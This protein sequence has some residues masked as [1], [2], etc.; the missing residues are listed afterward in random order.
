MATGLAV[1]SV[2]VAGVGLVRSP[3]AAAGPD[4]GLPLVLLLGG[5]IGGLLLAAV[6]T[7]HLLAPIESAY[8]RGGLSL[9]SSFATVVL[10]LVT[11]PL[12]HWAG[13]AGLFA[14]AVLAAGLGLLLA[15]RARRLGGAA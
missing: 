9:V 11:M 15:R 7:W 13:R 2:T 14:L 3:A 5:T 1:I 12:N 10:M 6:T 8:R 4:P